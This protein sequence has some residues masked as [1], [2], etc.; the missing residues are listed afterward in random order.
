M[1]R[2][3]SKFNELLFKSNYNRIEFRV[4]ILHGSLRYGVYLCKVVSAAI[5][6]ET[7]ADFLFYLYLPYPSFTCIILIGYEKN[8]TNAT[9]SRRPCS[10]TASTHAMARPDT[11]ACSST[12]SMHTADACG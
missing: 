9:T 3:Y 7:T 5:R 1:R 8:S 10:S 6:T 11:G 12:A 2:S 4:A